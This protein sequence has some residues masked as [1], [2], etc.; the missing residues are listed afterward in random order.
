MS[1]FRMRSV[2][3]NFLQFLRNAP[4]GISLSGEDARS[5]DSISVIERFYPAGT[6]LMEEGEIRRADLFISSGWA[7]SYKSMSNGQRV[8]A[9]FLQHGDLV[10]NAIAGKVHRSVQATTDVTT[11]EIK[12]HRSQLSAHW[13]YIASMMTRLMARNCDIAVEHLANVSRRR[14][15][16]R[17]AFL[18]LEAAYRHEQAGS[19]RTDQYVFP[20]TQRDLADALG[21]TTIHI[22][23]LL[24][25]LRERGLLR[26]HRGIVELADKAGLL[27]ITHFDPGYLA[28]DA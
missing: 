24:R 26:F 7:L 10:S 15:V 5:I 27:E 20:F 28:F 16:E 21:L 19:E 11:F 9:D 14:P 6:S 2:S 1:D 22:N 17:L 13:P 3:G 12:L 23:R 18:F 8:V 25:V 4:F